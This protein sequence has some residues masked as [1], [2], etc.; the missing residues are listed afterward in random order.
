MT[1]LIE[2]PEEVISQG[3]KLILTKMFGNRRGNKVAAVV[4]EKQGDDL[5]LVITVMVNFQAK[6]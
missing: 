1:L 2:G 6:K 3:P 4:M 5:W